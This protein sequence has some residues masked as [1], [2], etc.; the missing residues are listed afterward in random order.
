MKGIHYLLFAL[1]A[2]LL[3]LA[4]MQENVLLAVLGGLAMRAVV[5]LEVRAALAK[6]EDK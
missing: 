6:K 2:A 4:P 3:M 5:A 1:G